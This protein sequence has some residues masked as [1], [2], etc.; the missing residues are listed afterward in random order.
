MMKNLTVFFLL[1]NLRK[2]MKGRP[3]IKEEEYEKVYQ[4]H[5][6]GCQICVAVHYLLD[7]LHRRPV[8]APNDSQRARLFERHLLLLRCHLFPGCPGRA[9][10]VREAV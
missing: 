2:R 5:S 7:G 6:Q 1:D 9:A 4:G 10:D 8:L 3:N